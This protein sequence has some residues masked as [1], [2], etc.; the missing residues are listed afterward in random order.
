MYATIGAE[1]LILVTNTLS[2]R[3]WKNEI[4][5]KTD[6]PESDIGEYSG[7]TKEIKPITIATYNILTHRKRKG[8]DFTHFHI[9][10]A[11]NW[12]LIVYDEVHLLPFLYFV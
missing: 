4:L 9:F 1:T 7:E 3:Q 12:G 5:D 11:N 8:S 10:S 6:I 2:I